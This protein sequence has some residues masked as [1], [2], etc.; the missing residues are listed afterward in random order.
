MVSQA[1]G[2]GGRMKALGGA[3]HTALATFVTLRVR[4]SWSVFQTK[5]SGDVTG[6]S[7]L[8]RHSKAWR[9][10]LAGKC[11]YCQASGLEF[12]L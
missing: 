4:I 5:T 8:N 7:I 12:H 2:E 6:K 9:M 1:S 3:A 10:A 11:T